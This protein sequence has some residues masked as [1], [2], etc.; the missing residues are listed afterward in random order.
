MRIL[1]IGKYYPPYLGGM[2]TFLQDLCCGSSRAGHQ[3]HVLAHAHGGEDAPASVACPGG[4]N[5]IEV[6]R[7]RVQARLL[8]T[9][10]SLGFR[11]N[12]ERL[13]GEFEPDL[14]HLHLP[15]PSAFWLLA[16]KRARALPWIVHWHADVAGAQLGAGFRL[17]YRVYCRLEQRLLRQAACIIATSPPYLSASEPLRPWLEKCRVIPLGLDPARLARP[18]PGAAPAWPGEA[19]LKV[20]AVGRLTYYKGFRYLVDAMNELPQA[21]LC[22]AGGGELEVALRGQ[23]ADL[24]LEQRVRLQGSVSDA[25]LAGLLQGCDC[26]CLP[27][28]DRAEAFGMVLLEAMQAGKPL[29]VADVAGSGMGWVVDVDRT[30]LKVTPRDSDSLVAALRRLMDGPEL[31]AQLG[32]AANRKFRE[33]FVIDEVVKQISDL[34]RE[35]GKNRALA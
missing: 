30:G 8:Y 13:I 3:V 31:L 1:H 20:L 21:A 6:T 23:I 17:A 24:G 32:E 25:E 15:N 14:L 16:S 22:I 9:P 18:A 27:S 12:L 19:K 35:V 33:Q 34:Y 2:E 5:S 26:L 4:D 28:V 11:R 10:I 29:V 7:S